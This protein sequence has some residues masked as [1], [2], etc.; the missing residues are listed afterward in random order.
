MN[1]L[2]WNCGRSRLGRTISK[3]AHQHEIDVIV[4][5]EVTDTPAQLLAELNK[6][7]SFL[8]DFSQGQCKKICMFTRFPGEWATP[9]HEASRYTIRRLCLPAKEEV[10][11]VA[12]HLPSPLHLS[13]SSRN[14]SCADLAYD[15]RRVERQ[16]QHTRTILVGDLNVNP[17]DA[18]AVNASGLHG[19]ISRHIAAAGSR[20]VD[21]Q[22]YPFFYNPMWSLYG[23]Q[24][25]G[26]PATYHYRA[27]G[28]NALFWHMYDQ[29]MIRR[30]LIDGFN[31]NS[32]RIIDTDGFTSFLSK[33][34]VPD[35][36][37]FS[38]HLPIVFE[39][40]F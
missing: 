20:T 6:N 15:I 25:A 36:D 12:A 18:G 17:F 16:E 34:G 9:V 4:L 22:D 33:V 8:F 11:L 40:N 35:K 31:P 19:V 23:D 1:F 27:P 2:F 3:L 28:H 5:A 26:P 7:S 13:E 30:D 24:T 39:V 10:L 29:V 14:A 38:D 21:G 37:K 32:L